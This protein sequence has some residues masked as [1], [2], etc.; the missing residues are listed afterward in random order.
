[1]RLQQLQQLAAAM[2][3]FSECADVD[4]LLATLVA[5]IRQLFHI[6]A[7][8]VWLVVDEERLRLHHAQGVAPAA[9][10]SL[11]LLKMPASGQPAVA[12]RLYRLGYRSVLVAPLRVSTRTLGMVAVGSQRA[13][14]FGRLDAESF[15]ILG[16]YA[17]GCLE[18]LQPSPT[19]EPAEAR[20]QEAASSDLEVQ[21][22]RIYL[23]N[24]FI[25]RIIHDLSNTMT[26]I[27]GRV[28]LLL[29]RLRGE[30]TLQHLGAA[31]RA[32][33]EANQ[34]IRHI[35]DLASGHLEP[36][37]VLVDINQFVQD[38]LQIAQSTWFR[39]FRH[40]RV[41][42]DVG[43]DLNPVPA[44]PARASDLRI[45]ILCLL[46][47]AM[48][49]LHAGGGLMVRTWSEADRDGPAIFISIIDEPGQPAVAEQEEG[50]G[51]LLRQPLTAE[52]QRALVF[53]QAIISNLGG[54]ITV[55]RSVSGGTTTTLIF[56]VGRSAAPEPEVRAGA[57]I[58]QANLRDQW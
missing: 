52:S 32:I 44:L 7:G 36:G 17:A 33:N 30:V 50:I 2:Q 55:Q 26:T 13:R 11:Q 12:R 24:L 5:H 53:V 56:S 43:A 22:E 27:S 47:H 34:L 31:L 28:E 25:S 6:E 38:S 46:R 39:E 35:R 54:R 40:T 4:A 20:R 42:V 37:M 23:L 18:R 29:N 10:S 49:A 14:R 8:L 9:S 16:Q 21:R 48:D 45:A 51:L 19:R 15:K 57:Q 3:A 41:P 1:M 58:S